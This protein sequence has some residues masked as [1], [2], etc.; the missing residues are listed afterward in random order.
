MP[1]AAPTTASGTMGIVTLATWLLTM[2]AGG[3]MLRSLIRHGALRQQRAVRDGLHP[4]VLIGHFSLALT[5]AA[6]WISYLATG[7]APLAWAAVGLLMPTIGLG[8]CTVTLWTPYP[9]S[10]AAAPPAPAPVTPPAV[11]A[12]AMTDDALA[13]RLVEDVIASL[14]AEPPARPRQR[15]AQAAAV[16]PFGHGL[17]AVVTF[18]LAVVTATGAR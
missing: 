7:W 1:A 17:A 15:R 5:G 13:A 4:G 16:I 6:A 9:R 11:L 8:I 18:V 2:S 3:Y 14:P 12:R 10:P